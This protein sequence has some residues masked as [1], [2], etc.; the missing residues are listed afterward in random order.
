LMAYAS[1]DTQRDHA[2][3]ETHRAKRTLT[4]WLALYTI[5][6]DISERERL[7][8]RTNVHEIVQDV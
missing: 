4:N 1:R 5:E 2:G 3:V 7:E 8:L 6:A